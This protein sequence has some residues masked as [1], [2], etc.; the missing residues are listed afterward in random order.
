[1]RVVGVDGC[2]AGW[3]AVAIEH[4]V[5]NGAELVQDIADIVG[6]GADATMI[7][8]PIGLPD[9][10]RRA[11]DLAARALLA[12]APGARPGDAS[13]VFLDLRRPLLALRHDAGAAYD[14]AR[15]DG[16]GL[17]PFAFNLLEKIAALDA[18]LSP[19]RQA[20]VRECHPELAFLRLGGGRRVKSKHPRTEPGGLEQRREL[21][22]AAGFTELSDWL[23]GLRGG[24][25]RAD[26]LLDAC[27]CALAA[28]DAATGAGRRVPHAPE[29]DATGLRMEIWY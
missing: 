10:G 18:V 2:R 16:F 15:R 11:C 1:M 14:W 29:R 8:M 9:S 3:L 19:R 7:D 5:A 22:L 21:L 13:R 4:G 28:R 17:S 12:S 6:R 25:A 26:D 24:A 23:A 27:A 20:R